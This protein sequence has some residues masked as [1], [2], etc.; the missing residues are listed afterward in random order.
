MAQCI[1]NDSLEFD[2]E[3]NN[4]LDRNVITVNSTKEI[5]F[6]TYECQLEYK[7]IILE[8][9]DTY[10]DESIVLL[11]LT[12]DGKKY[13]TEAILRKGIKCG[14][15]INQN[16]LHSVVEEKEEEE[17][18]S[19][20]IIEEED[21]DEAFDPV[22]LVALGT[23][24]QENFR[25]KIE[26]QSKLYENKIYEFE[27]KKIEVLKNLENEFDKN[28]NFLKE[29]IQEKLTNF[30][31]ITDK[32][33][34][35]NFL[36]ESKD[37]D[38]QVSKHYDDLLIKIKDLNN[39][40]KKE[41]NTLI[42]EKNKTVTKT[43]NSF[44]ENASNKYKNY[45]DQ[46]VLEIKES[47]DESKKIFNE[48]IKEINKLK[49]KILDSKTYNDKIDKVLKTVNE[50]FN[51]LNNKF[52]LLSEN[53]NEEYNQLLAAV[54]KKDAVEYKTILK[55][56]IE[57]VELNVIKEQL[58]K[59]ITENFNSEITTVKRYAEMASAGGGTNAV[60]YAEGGT[61]N[62]ALN[63]NGSI[64]SGGIN[65]TD[66][67][68]ADTSITLQDVTDNGNTTTND[69]S[70]SGTLFADTILAHSLL[71]AG[72]LDIGFE[73]SGFN[74][75]GSVSASN[76]IFANRIIAE[77][78]LSANGNLYP[79]TIAGDGEV[80]VANGD[81]NLVFGH[82]EKL[83]LQIRNDEGSEIDAGTPI[84]SRGEI[85]GSERIKVGI[86]DASDPA[87]MPAIGIAETTLNT[88][89][90][91]D[92]FAI[93]NGVYN[94]NISGFTDLVVGRNLYVASGGGLTNVKPT[95]F[96]NL[97]QNI[98]T[99][100]K[101]GAGDTML[102]GM[103]VSSI[104][105]TNDIPNL[106]AKAI[107]YGQGDYYVQQSLSAAITD[108]TGVELKEGGGTFTSIISSSNNL[109]AN[110]IDSFEGNV[111]NLNACNITVNQPTGQI[112][113]GNDGICFTNEGVDVRIEHKD[114]VGTSSANASNLIINAS[115]SESLGTGTAG[116]LI[117]SAGSSTAPGGGGG[118][119][120][121]CAGTGNVN[122]GDIYL[123]ADDSG[124]ATNGCIVMTTRIACLNSPVVRIEDDSNFCIG[125]A[126]ANRTFIK[127]G[128]IRT[129]SL[130]AG[131]GLS[132]N[133]IR[134]LR[135]F[136]NGNRVCT[137]IPDDTLQS[138][139]DN[140]STTT[141]KLS[142][143]STLHG[144]TLTADGGGILVGTGVTNRQ[145]EN[146][147]VAGGTDNCNHA[148]HSF[149]GGGCRNIICATE[150]SS[151]IGGGCGNVVD[152]NYGIIVGG[153][154][155]DAV[156]NCSFV[157]GGRENCADTTLSVIGGGYRNIIDTCGC[158]FIGSG[159]CNHVC[160]D[161]GVVA[162]G[163]CNRN[164]GK[165]GVIVGGCNNNLQSGGNNCS[166]FIGGGR[167]NC[168]QCAANDSI[169]VGGNQNCVCNGA[170]CVFVG[171]GLQ[172]HVRNNFGI[173]VG[174]CGNKVCVGTGSCAGFIG[175]G[176]SNC[177]IGASC[178][179]LIV[180]GKTNKICGSK[181][182]G[183][184]GGCGNLINGKCEAFI[185]GTDITAA[186][187][188]TTHVDCLHIKSGT[189]LGASNLAGVTNANIASCST[190]NVCNGLI[191]EVS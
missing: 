25:N 73:L 36:N 87:K 160:G 58:K 57:D 39:F 79:Q 29:D 71:S 10:N 41:I 20:E 94:E 147:S 28:L 176:G 135:I 52:K 99:I 5:Y 137:S 80:I 125:L 88:S 188:C 93:I 44:L 171:G 121:I 30:L 174:G 146:S 23:M 140:G 34:K 49:S 162:G 37:L 98:G 77:T 189:F 132:A 50:Q 190:I 11:E 1:I 76:D 118:D 70:S 6:D 33:N 165:F 163:C 38:K 43:V 106:S 172:N 56:K 100:L 9:I 21:K 109:S 65:L 175:G 180:A 31:K 183:I 177:L 122:G 133:D 152:G 179:S 96:G 64:L 107:F 154:G 59:E 182:S 92:G 112:D 16:E 145:Y 15:E 8:K 156:G 69:I 105:R 51:T 104:D 42:E 3:Y 187:T 13:T 60:Q 74:V 139:T 158:G 157:G 66:I 22:N 48:K 166:Q 61:M 95:G 159:Q 102:Q 169:I 130:S 143:A 173:I 114:C 108:A 149:I 19:E 141:N 117:L 155:N 46:Q 84:Y 110:K 12:I 54:N 4:T 185:I 144:Y 148:Q 26:E 191:V 35:E 136:D 111:C 91:Q 138:V 186:C 142:S 45:F 72:T 131:N 85:G 101:A 127:N 116:C 123:N 14:L 40:N 24:V 81:G 168:I 134:G 55:E 151:F 32:E 67:F 17:I 82:G 97:I 167:S 2:F 63:V 124:V 153:K 53:K 7:K 18:I 103:K 115:D 83:H 128:A 86:A 47:S 120:F 129:Q 161:A 75:T 119:V 126:A 27:N 178:Y 181:F 164:C 62:G 150:N 78:T 90:T 89:S 184:L 170:C 68:N 113:I